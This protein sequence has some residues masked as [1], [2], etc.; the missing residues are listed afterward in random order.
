MTPCDFLETLAA[1]DA[2]L[3]LIGDPEGAEKISLLVSSRMT[4]PPNHPR[5]MCYS[6]PGAISLAEVYLAPGEFI[7]PDDLQPKRAPFQFSTSR[8][9]LT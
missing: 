3:E 8:K 5:L 6:T 9:I 7:C 1:L 2:H 4:P